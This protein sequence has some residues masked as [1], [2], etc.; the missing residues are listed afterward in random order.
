M[1]EL[2]QENNSCTSQFEAVSLYEFQHSWVRPS[3]GEKQQCLQSILG[4]VVLF[5]VSIRSVSNHVTINSKHPFLL[6]HF[7]KLDQLNLSRLFY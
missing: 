1:P 4:V 6:I 7:S 5:K 2:R 3:W